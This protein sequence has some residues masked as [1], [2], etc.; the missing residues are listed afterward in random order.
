M[1]MVLAGNT[2]A[3]THYHITMTITITIIAIKT[4]IFCT[5]SQEFTYLFSAYISF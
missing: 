3:S 4:V 2:I 5:M 1:V